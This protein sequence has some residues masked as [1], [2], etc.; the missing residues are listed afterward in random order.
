MICFESSVVLLIQ[1]IIRSYSGHGLGGSYTT[2]LNPP[3]TADPIPSTDIRA[4]RV[5]F[6]APQQEGRQQGQNLS[7]KNHCRASFLIDLRFKSVFSGSLR[8]SPRADSPVASAG[9]QP[10]RRSRKLPSPRSVPGQS[11]FS[12][13]LRES[14]RHRAPLFPSLTRSSFDPFCPSERAA[15]AVAISVPLWTEPPQSSYS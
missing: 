7:G 3:F 12:G 15:T 4:D 14:H 13:G 5:P 2:P 11:H 8:C 6:Q 1:K 10:Q 9:I